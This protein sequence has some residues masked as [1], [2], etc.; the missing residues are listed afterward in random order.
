MSTIMQHPDITSAQRTGYP[1]N[2]AAENPDTPEARKD[3]IDEYVTDL[4]KWL[5]LGYPDILEE[6]I[7]MSG[8]LCAFSYRDWLR[9]E[10]T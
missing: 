4:V 6:F 10:T 2:C 5:R 1:A 3:Y 9:G 8:Q 7:E